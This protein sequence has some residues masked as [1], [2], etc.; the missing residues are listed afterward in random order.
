MILPGAAG[1]NVFAGCYGRRPAQ[2][3]DQIA[4]PTSFDAKNAKAIVRIM[5]SDAFNQ[6]R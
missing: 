4:M 2:H 6:T 1:L 5:E 3:R